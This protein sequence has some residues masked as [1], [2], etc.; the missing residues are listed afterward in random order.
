MRPP[1][2]QLKELLE[3]PL[4]NNQQT[5]S[6]IGVYLDK[7][8]YQSSAPHLVHVVD[9]QPFQQTLAQVL[10]TLVLIAAGLWSSGKLEAVWGK[11]SNRIVVDEVAGMCVSLLWIPIRVEYVLI[12][13]LLFRFFDIVK[14]LFIRRIEKLPAG[15]GVM[16]DDLLAGVYANVVLQIFIV[17]FRK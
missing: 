11:D 15:W 16:F 17:I 14:P 6:Q 13:F 10:G 1:V 4:I 9:L 3:F 8:L 12:S 7:L 5:I 2:V